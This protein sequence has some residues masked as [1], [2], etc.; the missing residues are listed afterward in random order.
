MLEARLLVAFQERGELLVVL[1]EKQVEGIASLV[2]AWAMQ[3]PEDA[4]LWVEAQPNGDARKAAIAKVASTWAAQD[5][6]AVRFWIETLSP[7]ERSAAELSMK[8]TANDESSSMFTDSIDLRG[9]RHR[10]RP[11]L[12]KMEN[13]GTRIN[14][15][16]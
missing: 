4:A 10:G 9:T 5:E 16:N 8:T 11:S 2:R 13:P 3:N 7:E 14:R 12:S 1:G 15:A 6:E